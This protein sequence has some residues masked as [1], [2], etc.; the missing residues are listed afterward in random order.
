MAAQRPTKA[1]II[2][3]EGNIGRRLTGYLRS[4]GWEVKEVDIRPRWREDFWMADIN[5]P[6][7]LLPAFD[8]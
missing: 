5:N 7:D 8:W 6:L 3:S 2:G 4:R 1:L